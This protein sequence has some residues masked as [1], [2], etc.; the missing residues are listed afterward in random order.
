MSV[1]TDV[2]ILDAGFTCLPRSHRPRPCAGFMASESMIIP[3]SDEG[4]IPARHPDIDDWSAIWRAEAHV[5]VRYAHVAM[6][7]WSLNCTL[8]VSLSCL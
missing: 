4:L 2:S 1:M 6:L 5:S 3:A 7:H 8:L